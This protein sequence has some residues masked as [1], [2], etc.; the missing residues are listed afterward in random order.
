MYYLKD[1]VII[2]NLKCTSAQKGSL[3]MKVSNVNSLDFQL[4]RKAKA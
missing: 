2:I 1:V 3:F 4:H